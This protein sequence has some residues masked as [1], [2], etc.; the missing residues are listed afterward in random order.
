MK[1]R[2]R[3]R[4]RLWRGSRSSRV[5]SEIADSPVSA[6]IDAATTAAYSQ[7]VPQGVATVPPTAGCSSPPLSPQSANEGHYCAQ[8]APEALLQRLVFL[9]TALTDEAPLIVNPTER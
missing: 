6:N 3:S 4:C 1:S 2:C 5:T 8:N 9:E 7:F